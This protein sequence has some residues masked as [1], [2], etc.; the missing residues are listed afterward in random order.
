MW[1]THRLL[2]PVTSRTCAGY[3]DRSARNGGRGDEPLEQHLF[4][5][6]RPPWRP[7][8][9][10]DRLRSTFRP[11]PAAMAAPAP[12]RRRPP[13]RSRAGPASAGGRRTRSGTL[14]D[15]LARLRRGQRPGH[16]DRLDQRRGGW[17]VPAPAATARP[18]SH[19]AYPRAYPRAHHRSCQRHRSRESSKG[20]FE[21]SFREGYSGPD[22]RGS[23]ERWVSAASR[24]SQRR[25]GPCHPPPRTQP[26]R[27]IASVPGTCFPQMPS[28]TVCPGW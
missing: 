21:S 26:P 3:R 14:A 17:G 11:A 4:D 28:L 7:P 2:T 22:A 1:R 9:R 10:L 25:A 19:G 8:G 24:R 20:P 16:T 15:H 18:R 13:R 6:R 5:A 12:G 23:S 27:G